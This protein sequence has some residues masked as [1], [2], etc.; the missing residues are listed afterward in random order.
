MKKVQNDWI[1]LIVFLLS[2][3]TFLPCNAALINRYGMDL[4]GSAPPYTISSS[5]VCALLNCA[6]LP[7]DAFEAYTYK[8]ILISDSDIKNCKTLKYIFKTYSTHTLDLEVDIPL[9]TNSPY[10]FVIYVFGGGWTGGTSGAFVKQSKYLASRGIAGVRISYSLIADG[11][12]F[13]LG[14]Q[15]LGEAFA[16]IKAHADEWKLDMTRFGYAG[17]SAGTPLASLAAMKHNGNGCKLFM[18]CNGI[19]DFVNHLDGSWG[20]TSD[21]LSE[22]PTRA[23]RDVISSINF[24]PK[25]PDSIPAIAVYHGTGDVTISCLQSIAL[26]DSVVKKGGKADK[27]IYNYYGHGFFNGGASDMF[28][29]IT[30]KM[31]EFAKS[32]FFDQSNSVQ[33]TTELDNVRMFANNGILYLDGVEGSSIDVY[34]ILGT[35]I[36]NEKTFNQKCQ[37]NLP[38]SGMYIVKITRNGV[39][40]S[41]KIFIY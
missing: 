11:G 14:M 22:Y 16:F 21:Y 24:I 28:E 19:Y 7:A 6:T 37:F 4:T 25:T 41:N 39:S 13:N 12:T 29:T 30:I 2:T 33:N 26:C 1:V 40:K 8:P 23:S 15:E 35:L 10:P 20:K 31:Y 34:N 32:V 18:G 17:G 27:N 5:A 38:V 3:L 9:G 36:T